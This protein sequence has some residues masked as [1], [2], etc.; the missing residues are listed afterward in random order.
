MPFVVVS[1]LGR[2]VI[3]RLGVARSKRVRPS[4]KRRLMGRLGIAFLVREHEAGRQLY[5]PAQWTV[6]RVTLDRYIASA[7]VENGYRLEVGADT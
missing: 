7:A 4:G 6:G 1:S 2:H 3:C 5:R